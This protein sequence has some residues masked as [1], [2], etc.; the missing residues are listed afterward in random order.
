MGRVRF[1]AA[2]I[3]I[4]RPHNF[5]RETGRARDSVDD[6]FNDEQALGTAES[7]EGCV[8]RQV[9][10]HDPAAEGDVRNVVG[11]V[12]MEQGPVRNGAGKIERPATVR[13]QID[14][15]REQ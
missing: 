6:F 12:E 9:G 11:V 1:A 4:A 14:F 7:A 5:R 2:A 3:K 10:F 15:C 13:K 8:R